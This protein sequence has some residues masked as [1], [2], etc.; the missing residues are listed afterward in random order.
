MMKPQPTI[1]SAQLIPNAK[2]WP[3]DPPSKSHLDILRKVLATRLDEF[4]AELRSA[5]QSRHSEDSALSHSSHETN[6]SYSDF[7]SYYEHLNNA[8]NAW[9]ALSDSEKNN[10]YHL[11]FARAFAREQESH[12]ETKSKLAKAEKR[13]LHNEIQ[14]S[15]LNEL[16]QPNEFLKSPLRAAPY[17]GDIAKLVADKL[18]EGSIPGAEALISKWRPSVEHHRG[19][20]R[21]FAEQLSDAAF[22]R[23]DTDGDRNHETNSHEPTAGANG[24]DGHPANGTEQGH[25]T[26]IPPLDTDGGDSVDASGEDDDDMAEAMPPAHTHSRNSAIHDESMGVIDPS[27]SRTDT[28]MRDTGDFGAASFMEN[29]NGKVEGHSR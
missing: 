3:I 27:L 8:Y 5:R 9:S 25:G 12:A 29:L 22:A 21:G 16:Q 7:S 20:Q 28:T 1:L 14:I 4:A 24:I 18:G 23:A 10:Q 6:E 11:E 26:S 15:R 19:W 13:T 17:S 2:Y